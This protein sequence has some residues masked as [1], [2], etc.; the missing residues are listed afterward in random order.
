MMTNDTSQAIKMETQLLRNLIETD[1]DKTK[2]VWHIIED[3][4][5]RLDAIAEKAKS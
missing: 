2:T 5:D 4:A 3:I 1:G